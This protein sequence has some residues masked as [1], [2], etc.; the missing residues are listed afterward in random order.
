[1]F[2]TLGR[3]GSLISCRG[4]I[5]PIPALPPRAL[6]D[7]TGC[8]DTFIAGYV[9]H[10]MGSDDV[11]RAGRFAAALAAYKLARPGPFSGDVRDVEA[12]L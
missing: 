7:A 10:R 6:V 11:V 12:L 4:E 8:G 5:H 9:F 2:I 1:M 3:E